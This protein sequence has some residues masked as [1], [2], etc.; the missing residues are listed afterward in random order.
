MLL[1]RSEEHVARWCETWKLP[2]GATLTLAH[3]WRLAKAW[4]GD[5]LSPEWRPKSAAESQALLCSVG[6]RAKFW[7]LTAS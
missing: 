1:F 2:R 6:L 7:Q 3:G 4:Y 5:R